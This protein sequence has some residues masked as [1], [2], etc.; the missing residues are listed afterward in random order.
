MPEI[1]KITECPRDA[2]QGIKPFIPTEDKVRYLNALLRCGFDILDFGSFVS[3]KAIP[4]M[5]DTA[6]VLSQLDLSDTETRLLAIIGNLRGAEDACK[7]PEISYLGFPFSIS[8]TFLERNIKSTIEQSFDM[9]KQ[10]LSLCQKHSKSLRVYISMAF[11]NPYG[12][13]WSAEILL[14]WI[15]QLHW[16]GVRHI[17]LADTT[18]E[19]EADTMGSVLQTI[20]PNYGEV[21]FG[22]HLHNKSSDWKQ[23][24]AAAY[25]AGCRHYDGVLHGLGGCPMAGPELVGNIRTTDLLYFFDNQQANTGIEWP[26][27]EKARQIAEQILP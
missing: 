10:M 2:M 16:A 8:P 25:Q 11:G 15:D 17:V 13:D 18:N 4:Q 19:G 27:V 3:A 21:E 26:R 24:I 12:D 5:R 7:H 22:L 1:V 14:H 23:K 9:V 20:V 6:E